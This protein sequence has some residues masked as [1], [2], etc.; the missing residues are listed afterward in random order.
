MTTA[1]FFD[2]M[3]HATIIPLLMDERFRKN[4]LPFVYERL[5]TMLPLLPE[6]ARKEVAQLIEQ[7]LQSRDEDD[8]HP[9]TTPNKMATKYEKTHSEE[10]FPPLE[11]MKRLPQNLDQKWDK[12]R[13]RMRKKKS[14]FSLTPENRAKK[15]TFW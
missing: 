5:Q 3:E 7:Y 12:L 6:K 15:P 9:L 2:L 14:R 8:I 10:V 11:S 13:N 1:D 4:N